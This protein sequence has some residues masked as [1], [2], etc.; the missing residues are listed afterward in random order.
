LEYFFAIGC[1]LD[2]FIVSDSRGAVQSS[3]AGPSRVRDGS[4]RVHGK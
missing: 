4:K 3:L 2:A 1:C